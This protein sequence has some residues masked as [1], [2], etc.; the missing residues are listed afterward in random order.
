VS[1]LPTRRSGVG[2]PS[3]GERCGH[4]SSLTTLGATIRACD[5]EAFE[6]YRTPKPLIRKQFPLGCP[7]SRGLYRVEITD[8]EDEGYTP[9]EEPKPREALARNR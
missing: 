1:R 4:W 6:P 2:A 3:S 9:P 7:D 5:L 8:P